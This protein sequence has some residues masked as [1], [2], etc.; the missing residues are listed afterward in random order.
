VRFDIAS[1][2]KVL[3]D[4]GRENFAKM[5]GGDDILFVGYWSE[6]DN[7]VIT[8]DKPCEEHIKMV[9]DDET[10]PIVNCSHCGH[11]Q[12]LLDENIHTDVL[13]NEF[14]RC[15]DCDGTTDVI[16]DDEIGAPTQLCVDYTKHQIVNNIISQ[17]KDIEVDGET[18]E[19]ILRKVGMEEQMLK[20]LFAQA[21]NADV[22]YLHDVRNGNA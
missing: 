13:G 1:Y 2:E 12:P 10:Y 19:H 3:K 17:L 7:S 8:Y 21:T 22:E 5:E 14:F 4:C 20:Q 18:M 11:P 16:D 9:Y 15:E 6:G